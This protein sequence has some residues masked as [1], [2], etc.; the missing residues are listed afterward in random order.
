MNCSC[1][2]HDGNLDPNQKC[3]NCEANH[4]DWIISYSIYERYTNSYIYIYMA[5]MMYMNCYKCDK[6]YANVLS[7]LNHLYK[8]HNIYAL[9]IND[10]YINHDKH[11]FGRGGMLEDWTFI[12][13]VLVVKTII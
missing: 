2:C 5:W 1:Q 12:T 11:Y 6:E 4:N 7:L 10:P 8:T 13:I 3:I 9:D